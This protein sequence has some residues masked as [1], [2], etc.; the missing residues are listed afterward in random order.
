MLQSMGSQK[1]GHGLQLNNYNKRFI[2]FVY[3]LKELA[4]SFIHLYYYFLCLYFIYFCSD[5]YDHIPSTNFGFA[6]SFFSICFTYKGSL[7]I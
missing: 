4:F 7:F 3:L 2:H 6:Y 1:V 5:F